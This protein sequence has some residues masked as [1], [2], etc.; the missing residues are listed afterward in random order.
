[1]TCEVFVTVM[2]AAPTDRRR[3]RRLAIVVA[4]S[5]S[6]AASAKAISHLRCRR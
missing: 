3:C 5:V 2:A 6:P 4:A 1:M